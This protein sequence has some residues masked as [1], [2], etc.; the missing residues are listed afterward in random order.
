MTLP[1]AI[2]LPSPNFGYP[3]PRSEGRMGQP[4]RATVRHRIVGSLASADA[5]FATIERNASTHFGIGHINGRLEVHQ[6][7][8]LSDAAWGNGLISEPTAQVVKDN[9]GVNPNLYTL[10]IEHEDGGA[11]GR[12]V[13]QPDTWAASIELGVL[14]QSGDIA[15][16]RSAGIRIR[17]DATA[18]QLAAIPPTVDGHIDHHAI[19]GPAKPFCWR[20][21]LDDPGFVAGSPSRRDQLLKA[22][23]AAG[24]QEDP[25]VIEELNADL[26]ACRARVRRL[27]ERRDALLAQI[28]KLE[29]DLDADADLQRTVN[30]LRARIAAVKELAAQIQEA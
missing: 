29:T 15:A 30:R 20:P 28:A 9:P 11:A 18:A 26:D 7:V 6:Y 4:V 13:V 1:Q 21:W 17:S 14:L 25:A 23:R 8:N 10:S 19:S 27:I 24:T 22:L 16:I 3:T 2:W 12:G 5:V